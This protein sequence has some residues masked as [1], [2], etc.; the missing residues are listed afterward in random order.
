M[1]EAAES[2]LAGG[3]ALLDLYDWSTAA[4]TAVRDYGPD[5]TIA[6]IICEWRDTSERC[7]NEWRRRP[8]PISEEQF[9]SWLARQL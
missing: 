5:R 7:R 9:R 8:D 2:Y 6:P 1:G 3:L 4:S